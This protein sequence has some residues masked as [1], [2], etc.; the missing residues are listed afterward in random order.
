M[1]F[2]MKKRFAMNKMDARQKISRNYQDARQLLKQ[3]QTNKKEPVHDAR[4]K[5]RAKK[6]QPLRKEILKIKSSSSSKKPGSLPGRTISNKRASTA[7]PERRNSLQKKRTNFSGESMSGFISVENGKRKL[8]EKVTLHQT[9]LK[10]AVRNE[11]AVPAK[12][13]NPKVI[14]RNNDPIKITLNNPNAMKRPSS[15]SFHPYRAKVSKQD[16]VRERPRRRHEHHPLPSTHDIPS[17]SMHDL[18][19]RSTLDLLSRSTRDLP[20]ANQTP[21]SSYSSSSGSILHRDSPPRILPMQSGIRPMTSASISGN[22]AS[23]IPSSRY[24]ESLETFSPLEGTKILVSNLHPVVVEDD[25][26]ELFSV[27]G[28][29]R[30]AR[31]VGIGKAEVV[32]VQKEH[33]M[34]AYHKYNNRDLDGQPMLMKLMLKDINP[35]N[36]IAYSWMNDI[37]IRKN[38][39]TVEIDPSVLQ[40]SLFKTNSSGISSAPVV[41]TV[42][43]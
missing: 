41:F 1:S 20:L 23:A 10:V 25:I 14:P 43:I 5:I 19:S 34:I 11:L 32:F 28:P 22:S 18:P 15:S 40:R 7:V 29:V 27:V 31:M 9:G 17:R 36:K 4:F 3:R 37:G 35:S 8:L 24:E 33:A 38:R 13:K 21:S 39:G 26:L 2:A 6:F 30:R 42:K 16:L 12:E